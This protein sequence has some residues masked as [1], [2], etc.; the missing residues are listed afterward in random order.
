MSHKI[1]FFDLKMVPETIKSQWKDDFD[2]VISSGQF[3]GGDELKNFEKV[4]SEMIGVSYSAGVGNGLDGLVIALK[5]LGIKSGEK[6][7]VPAHTFIATWNAVYLAGGIPIGVDVDNRGL[8]N[9]D[10]LEQM[11]EVP[12]FVIP[13][14]MHGI[15]VDMPR[16]MK[17]AKA[18]NCLVIEDASQAHLGKSDGKMLG[19]TSDIGVFSLYPSKNLGALGDGG[20]ITTNS[21]ETYSKI[22]SFQNYGADNANKYNHIDLGINSR[23]DSIQAALLTTNLSHLEEWTSRRRTIAS[24]YLNGIVEHNQLRFLNSQLDVSVWHHFPILVKNRS[25]LITYLDNLSI[26][27]EIHYPNLASDEFSK[28]MGSPKVHFKN[29][30]VIS[31]EILSLP[32]S[33]WHAKDQIEFV[34]ESVNSFFRV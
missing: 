25:K 2:R 32:I 21:K 16:L 6:V 18:N 31:S 33:P 22:R 19:S 3:I 12:R 4:W 9:L 11:I 10:L 1:P 13:V 20:V 29:A 34:C 23:L 8:M 26:G 5:A 24:I 27:T 15:S 7:A 30:E 17:W 14:H 28:F